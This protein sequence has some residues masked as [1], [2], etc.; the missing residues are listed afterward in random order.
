[1][2]QYM[3]RDQN[4]GRIVRVI[5]RLGVGGAERYVCSSSAH[6]DRARYPGVLICGSPGKD[7]RQWSEL[8]AEAR[9]EPV[10]IREMRRGLGL[11]DAA[12]LA[13][14]ASVCRDLRPAIIE[15]HTAKAGAL[16][17]LAAVA[18][19]GRGARRP[20]LIHVF[21]GHVFKGHFA[22][23]AVLGFLAIE[24]ALAR[25]SDV[26]IA[27]SSRVRQEL[28]EQY[29]IAPSR[30]IRVVPP[31]L[32]FAWVEHL[33]RRR[34]WLRARLGVDNGTVILGMVGR[35]AKIKN[36]PLMLRAFARF[37]QTGVD[38]RLVLIGDGEMRA[39]L[40]GLSR[41]LG[42]AQRVEFCGWVL[43]HADIFSDLDVTCLSSFNEGLP[44][45]LVESLAAGIPVAA[46]D[47]GGVRDVVEAEDG[48]LVA[49]GEV[50]AFSHALSKLARARARLSDQRSAAIRQK[51]ST[52][53]MARTLEGIYDEL[54]E[55]KLGARVHDSRLLQTAQPIR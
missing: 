51:Y 36:I 30:K 3:T 53:R 4:C 2:I 5:T 26:I 13:R 7:E 48:E 49:G 46:T 29:R 34:G 40:Q 25:L 27:V 55:R 35:L 12:A 37:L 18:A 6:V 11:H 17:R 41:S 45:A 54:V 15:T 39:E 33:S 22:S 43:Q 52:A 9:V 24:R 32:D 42:I 19:F 21:H 38:A 44:V 31:G 20:G 28:V 14:L 16:G 50:E 10:Y 47:V 8:C 23:P 1:L